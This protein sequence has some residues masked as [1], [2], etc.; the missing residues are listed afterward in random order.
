MMDSHNR[1]HYLPGTLLAG[2][3]KSEFHANEL[4]LPRH[5]A[6]MLKAQSER[7]QSGSREV[8]ASISPHKP[9]LSTLLL[10]TITEKLDLGQ[11]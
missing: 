1:K 10:G 5:L 4:T 11:T 2:G 7:L 3:K 6:A 9:L 8:P